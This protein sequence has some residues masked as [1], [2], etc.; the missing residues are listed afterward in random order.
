MVQ[1]MQRGIAQRTLRAVERSPHQARN[2]GHIG[3]YLARPPQ[4]HCMM[5][6]RV[7]KA[8]K[9]QGAANL[10]AILKSDE[11]LREEAA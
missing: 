1:S 5:I 3:L 9:N 10:K 2:R 11:R 7:I 4:Q 6:G 8:K